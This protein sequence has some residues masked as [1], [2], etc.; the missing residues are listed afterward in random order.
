MT[1][2]ALTSGTAIKVFFNIG[3]SWLFLSF[4]VNAQVV[5]IVLTG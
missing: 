1:A 5:N 4:A 2:S 3:C